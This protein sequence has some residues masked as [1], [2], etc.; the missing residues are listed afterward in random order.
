M[1]LSRTAV[2]SIAGFAMQEAV[3]LNCKYWKTDFYSE[4]EY[5]QMASVNSIG[6]DSGVI[7]GIELDGEPYQEAIRDLFGYTYAAYFP[8]SHISAKQGFRS[9]ALENS[10]SED[11]QYMLHEI[12]KLNSAL[13]GSGSFDCNDNVRPL[14]EAF[15]YRM[16]YQMLTDYNF[17]QK[18]ALVRE[19]SL[20]IEPMSDDEI[21][22]ILT[23]SGDIYL[24]SFKIAKILSNYRYEELSQKVKDLLI[25]LYGYPIM[26]P[27]LI[28]EFETDITKHNN[29]CNVSEYYFS[30]KS[31]LSFGCG[32]THGDTVYTR[33]YI[34]GKGYS[35]PGVMT[36]KPIIGADG[37]MIL[38][39]VIYGATGPTYVQLAIA[40]MRRRSQEILRRKFWHRKRS[41]RELAP[42]LPSISN[43]VLYLYPARAYMPYSMQYHIDDI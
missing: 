32:H 38:P 9:Y 29:Y 19:K 16:A 5:V 15:L 14:M 12:D 41:F 25:N 22:A 10:T 27:E 18:S 20:R 40:N 2:G 36:V 28:F 23:S 30:K 8:F 37:N 43:T 31:V 17:R 42:A 13:M 11:Q 26:E 39:N 6:P 21:K 33:P 7:F 4:Q 35:Q 34:V 3:E 24:Q 1:E